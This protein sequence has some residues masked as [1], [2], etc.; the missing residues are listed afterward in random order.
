M[1]LSSATWSTVNWRTEESGDL[2]GSIFDLI[3]Q[4]EDFEEPKH[5]LARSKI[6]S[7][8]S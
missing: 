3:R 2:W 1:L 5:A 7:L 4:A 8:A 6:P